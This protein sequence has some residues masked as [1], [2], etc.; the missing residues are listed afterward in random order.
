MTQTWHPVVSNHE[1]IDAEF[2]SANRRAHGLLRRWRW[3]PVMQGMTS[4]RARRIHDRLTHLIEVVG[5]HPENDPWWNQPYD[6]K[7]F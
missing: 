1:A 3:A 6:G 4:R 7:E 5:N 2:K